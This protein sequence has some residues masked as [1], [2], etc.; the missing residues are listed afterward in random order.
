MFLFSGIFKFISLPALGGCPVSESHGLRLSIAV[1]SSR[2]KVVELRS[3]GQ[4]NETTK[5]ERKAGPIHK[6]FG[7]GLSVAPSPYIFLIV[8]ARAAAL[9][10]PLRGES[11]AAPR[12]WYKGGYNRDTNVLGLRSVFEGFEMTSKRLRKLRDGSKRLRSPRN[13]FEAFAKS[14]QQLRSVCEGTRS[15]FE[16]FAKITFWLRSRLQI[17][18]STSRSVRA[19]GSRPTY[20]VFKE[21]SYEITFRRCCFFRKILFPHQC[22]KSIILKNDGAVLFDNLGKLFW[23]TDTRPVLENNYLKFSV[24][25]FRKIIL[26]HWSCVSGPK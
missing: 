19:D 24:W 7:R 9:S 10:N 14:S 5:S 18:R 21:P 20:K 23:T 17:L 11:A 16:A 26:D 6:D 13:N 2:R 3:G 4:W 12:L 15:N 1:T 25:E 8:R 22:G